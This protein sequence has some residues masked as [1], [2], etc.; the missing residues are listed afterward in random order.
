MRGAACAAAVFAVGAVLAPA[1]GAT[2]RALVAARYVTASSLSPSAAPVP[3]LVPG[4]VLQESPDLR[5]RRELA[6]RRASPLTPLAALRKRAARREWGRAFAS[7]RAYARGRLGRVSFAFVDDGGRVRS[8]LGRRTFFSA[9][10]VKAML[11]V[12]YLRRRGVRHSHLSPAVQ[13]VLDPMIRRSDNGAATRMY[14][15][16][17]SRGLERLA[18]RVGM[19]WFATSPNWGDTQLAATDQAVFFYG[20]DRFVPPFHRAYARLLLSHIIALQRWGIPE[21]VGHR[22]RVFF[23]GG[24]RPSVG[25]WIVNQSALIE[26][27]G[28]HRMSLS[29]LTDHDRTFGYGHETIRGIA[30]RLTR[31][32]VRR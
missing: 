14:D 9:S 22:A 10:L 30:A 2:P 12:A 13:T 6:A 18:R 25:G 23:K 4:R 20:I 3:E 21:V 31:P 7:A 28:G 8:W 29:V 17:G 24:W 19:R 27:P 26:G 5:P 11:L 32:F 16:V 1:A 15:V